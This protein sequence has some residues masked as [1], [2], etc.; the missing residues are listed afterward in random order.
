MGKEMD[1]KEEEVKHEQIDEL[2]EKIE[3]L[4]WDLEEEEKYKKGMY[5]D[6]REALE[7]IG[8]SI[9]MIITQIPEEHICS[10]RQDVQ[11]LMEQ[12]AK[13]SV[14]KCSL[15]KQLF[16]IESYEDC[17]EE[18]FGYLVGVKDKFNKVISKCIKYE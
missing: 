8:Y 17:V 18:S 14:I 4:R 12:Y 13:L 9:R 3:R 15:V 2:K 6:I 5:E 10:I 16:G 7:F 11:D 1:K